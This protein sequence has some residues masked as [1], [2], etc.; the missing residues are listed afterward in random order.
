MEEKLKQEL[1]NSLQKSEYK[2]FVAVEFQGDMAVCHNRASSDI[3]FV[4][5]VNGL[6]KM[7][8][9]AACRHGW[10]LMPFGGANYGRRLD[11]SSLGVFFNRKDAEVAKIAPDQN[12]EHIRLQ[13]KGIV[14]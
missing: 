13:K 5:A 9:K 3:A 1:I 7:W 6:A 14:K 2:D 10:E 4:N 11:D 8:H 12:P